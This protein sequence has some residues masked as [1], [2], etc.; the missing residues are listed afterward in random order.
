MCDK[1]YSMA[2]ALSGMQKTHGG[3]LRIIILPHFRNINVCSQMH[4]FSFY[5]NGRLQTQ[6]NNSSEDDKLAYLIKL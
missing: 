1:P 4:K 2:C 3:N 5:S 6:V